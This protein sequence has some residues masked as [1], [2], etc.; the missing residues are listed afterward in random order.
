M[1]HHNYSTPRPPIRKMGRSGISTTDRTFNDDLRDLYFTKD[2]YH[3]ALEENLALK[4]KLHVYNP[5]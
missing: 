3:R 1:S 5:H 2:I 4:S